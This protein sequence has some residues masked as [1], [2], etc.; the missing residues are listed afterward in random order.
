[1]IRDG[2]LA[3]GA[4]VCDECGGLVEA[5]ELVLCS[6]GY[7]RIYGEFVL[8]PIDELHEDNHPLAHARCADPASASP[9]AGAA[10]GS[11]SES[12]EDPLAANVRRQAAWFFEN[13]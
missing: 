10:G 5:G 8:G 7:Q 12:D 9:A 6:D 11:P 2:L 4:V 1:M 3:R 13:D